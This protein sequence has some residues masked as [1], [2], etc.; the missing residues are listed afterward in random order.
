ME[1]AALSSAILR[2]QVV[3]IGCSPPQPARDDS[4]TW[5]KKDL[6]KLESRES[7]EAPQN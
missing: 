2:R 5:C 3:Q 6:G 4:H 7:R 1:V